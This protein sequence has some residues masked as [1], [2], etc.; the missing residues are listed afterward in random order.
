MADVGLLAEKGGRALWPS[1]LRGYHFL[2]KILTLMG[3]TLSFVSV[4]CVSLAILRERPGSL[5]VLKRA[6]GELTSLYS[7][8][9]EI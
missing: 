9:L 7:A 1:L 5:G 6:E 3:A 8:D 4:V 2:E